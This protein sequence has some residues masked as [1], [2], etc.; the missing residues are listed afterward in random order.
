[1]KTKLLFIFLV[2]F[3]STSLKLY[4]QNSFV[5]EG[6]EFWIGFLQNWD[7]SPN[8]RLTI[9]V[10]SKFNTTGVLSIPATGYTQ[11]FTVTANQT[12]QLIIPNNIAEHY[13]SEIV[14]NKGVLIQTDDNVSV[15]Y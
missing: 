7:V 3:T 13:T 8:D 5:T 4:G 2:F 9:F 1:M 12:T 10:T 14:E 15:F 6:K 11:N